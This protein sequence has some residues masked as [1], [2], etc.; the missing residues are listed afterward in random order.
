MDNG[1]LH[2]LS[3]VSDIL[4][5]VQD[6]TDLRENMLR[7]LSEYCCV[8]DLNLYV[9]DGVSDNFRNC[10]ENWC[11]IEENQE[12]LG[13]FN[14]IAEHDFVINSKA[15][16][17]PA[18]IGDITIKLDSLYMPIV[19]GNKVFGL[20]SLNFGENTSV[21]M[22]FLF[23]MKIFASQ[24]SLKLQNII[25]DEQSRINVE[26]HDSMKNIAN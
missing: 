4:T 11:I 8:R 1:K 20:I 19:R 25:L 15:Y 18:V 13:A 14:T 5:K 2:F 3:E 26:F 6:T 16:K 12:I 7:I 22:E 17:L 23:L 9:Y 21:N 10:A 24:I